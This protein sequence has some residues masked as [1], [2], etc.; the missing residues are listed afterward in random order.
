MRLHFHT[1]VC[2]LESF[3]SDIISEE[4]KRQKIAFKNENVEAGAVAQAVRRMSYPH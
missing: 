4:N 3:L 2:H 1:D